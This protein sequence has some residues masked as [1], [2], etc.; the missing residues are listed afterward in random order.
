MARPRDPLAKRNENETFTGAEVR[1]RVEK[2]AASKRAKVVRTD[3]EFDVRNLLHDI[4]P[5]MSSQTAYTWTIEQIQSARDDQMR[6]KFDKPAKM[7]KSMRTDDAI[8]VAWT[9]RLAPQIGLS[10]VVKGKGAIRKEGESLFGQEGVGVTPGAVSDVHEILVNHGVSIGIN[11]W[12]PRRDGS[13]VDV[14]LRPWPMQWVRYDDVKRTLVT[15]IDGTGPEVPITHGDGRWVVFSKH[16]EEPWTKQAC[17]LPAAL[18]WS[19]HALGHRDWVAASYSQSNSKVKGELPPEFAFFDKDGSL[20]P[21]ALGFLEILKSAA[22]VEAM[23]AIVPPGAKMDYLTNPSTAYQIWTDLI[24]NAERA[25]ARIYLGTDG[26]LGAPG[27]APGVDIMAL[28]GVAN[29]LGEGD[30]RCL[31]R[32]IREGV[33]EPWAAI[34]F[35]SSEAAPTRDYVIPDADAQRTAIDFA[36]RMDAFNAGV[37]AAKANGFLIDQAY[38]DGLAESYGVPAPTVAP[39]QADVLLPTT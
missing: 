31:T 18:V 1:R 25:A 2:L 38:V 16:E 20:T 35:G 9:N 24:T 33:I 10:V 22:G 4:R 32:G 29:T 11:E 15:R 23:A 30:L 19:R 37:A 17:I 36:E 6:G 21:Q 3:D 34:N 27:G 12:T 28:F 13:R 26:T 8:F 14:K 7:A 39:T 5:P